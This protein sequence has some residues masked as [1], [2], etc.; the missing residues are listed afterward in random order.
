MGEDQIRFFGEE[1]HTMLQ[2]PPTAA[3]LSLSSSLAPS[4]RPPT[5]GDADMSP[6]ASRAPQSRGQGELTRFL[7]DKG[8]GLGDCRKIFFREGFIMVQEDRGRAIDNVSS[9]D[10]EPPSAV[11]REVTFSHQFVSPQR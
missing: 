3:N 1:M 8:K 11:S 10:A 7:N 2:R 5:Q 4:S 6:S 9:Q